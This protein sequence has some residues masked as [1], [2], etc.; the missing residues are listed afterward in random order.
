MV[1]RRG[2]LR[3]A[4][5]AA[6]ARGAVPDG[7]ALDAVRPGEV[8]D[9]AAD[10]RRRTSWSAATRWSRP[11][12][13]LAILVGTIVGGLLIAADRGAAL[14]GA[15]G[16]DRHR[17]RGLPREPPRAAAPPPAP[18]LRDR[19]EPAHRDAGATSSSRAA[20]A[21]C[22]CRSSAS[23]GSGSSARC[24]SRSFPTTREVNL[25]GAEHVVTLLLAMFSIGIGV[26]S[27]LCERLSGHKVEIGLVPFGSIGLTVFAFD[28]VFASRRRARGDR[29]LGV[30]RVPR[31]ARQLPRARRPR[32]DRPV[33]RLLHRAA[34]RADPEPLA[35]ARTSRASSPATT[36]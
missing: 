20:T 23:R 3:A 29:P 4:Q 6:A 8:R 14:L 35:S 34:L 1:A 32:A 7:P 28:L 22:S 10:L 30:A 31:R 21:R 36:S 11:G 2:R 24:S 25:G 18:D 26:G 33:R 15:G 12:T 17:R 27:L 9:P 19:L 13:S 5:P 16:G